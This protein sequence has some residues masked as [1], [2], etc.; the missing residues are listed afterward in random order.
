MS[1]DPVRWLCNKPDSIDDGVAC[2]TNAQAKVPN[3][4]TV[5]NFPISHCLSNSIKEQHC[6]IQYSV[7]ILVIVIT[8]NFV[9]M[10]CMLATFFEPSQTLVT[11]GDAMESFLQ[12]PDSSTAGNCTASWKSFKEHDWKSPNLAQPFNAN[13]YWWFQAPTLTRVL[14]CNLLYVIICVFNYCTIL[15]AIVAASQ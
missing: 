6:R 8:F 11:I 4:F 10:C 13:R 5:G 2:D 1:S 3:T 12:K 14:L 9:K 7:V 15:T